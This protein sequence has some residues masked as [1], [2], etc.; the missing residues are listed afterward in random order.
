M[1]K[2]AYFCLATDPVKTEALLKTRP[3]SESAYISQPQVSITNAGIL[4][5]TG[6]IHRFVCINHTNTLRGR[7]EG[8][9]PC[10]RAEQLGCGKQLRQG[11]QMRPTPNSAIQ[12]CI[13][14]EAEHLCETAAGHRAWIKSPRRPMKFLRT[15]VGTL[16]SSG[17]VSRM[18]LYQPETQVPLP[19][20]PD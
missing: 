9:L 20:L 17:K 15:M 2:T 10:L 18:Q 4:Q 11:H 14:Q 8:L 13:T 12:L 16:S 5:L 3:N 1:Q 6:I 19:T 7:Q